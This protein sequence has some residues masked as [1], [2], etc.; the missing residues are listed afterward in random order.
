MDAVLFGCLIPSIY[1]AFTD[2]T[3]R[4]LYDYI[5]IPI[6]VA[7]II[8]SVYNQSWGNLIAATVVFVIFIIMANKGGIAGGDVKFTTAIAV[9][10]GYPSIVYI[11][12]IASITGTIF[13]FYKL[14][15]MGLFQK[16]IVTFFR[17][18]YIRV[19][20]GI[21]GVIPKNELP[22]NDEISEEGIPFGTFLVIASWIVYIV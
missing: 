6:L 14:T 10:F 7:G 1:S 3:K 22:E 11:I 12:A 13:G 9:W 8:H 16:R 20:Y 19:I 15:K 18:I 4:Y 5:T 2:A 17:G 21:Q